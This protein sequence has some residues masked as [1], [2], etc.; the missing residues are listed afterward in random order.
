MYEHT[1]AYIYIYMY[2]HIYRSRNLQL[3]IYIHLNFQLF[4]HHLQTFQG[5]PESKEAYHGLVLLL[6][7][8]LYIYIYFC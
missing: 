5:E 2:T 4:K 6:F 7:R 1:C 8:R 3:Y